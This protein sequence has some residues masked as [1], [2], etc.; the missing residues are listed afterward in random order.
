MGGRRIHEEN[1]VL[2]AESTFEET[3]QIVQQMWSDEEEPYAGTHYRLEGA[4]L[5]AVIYEESRFR[6]DARSS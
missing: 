4:L 2:K 6:A 3:L 5:A 1:P